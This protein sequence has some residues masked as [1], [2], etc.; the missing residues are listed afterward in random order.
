MLPVARYAGWQA[1]HLECDAAAQWW[2]R[3]RKILGL[4]LAAGM[5]IAH[6]YEAFAKKVHGP[7]RNF[8]LLVLIG[9]VV[10]A[11]VLNWSFFL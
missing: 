9:F 5:F 11:L 10:A 8:S 4:P 1:A 7:M 6:R 3:A 2:E